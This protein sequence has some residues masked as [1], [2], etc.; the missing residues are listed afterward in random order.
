MTRL[1]KEGLVKT[2]SKG[3]RLGKLINKE[4]VEDAMKKYFD[5]NNKTTE[6]TTND[7]I[8]M[9]Q[10]NPVSI[11][12]CVYVM[13]NGSCSGDSRGDYATHITYGPTVLSCEESTIN[14]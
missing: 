10:N 5:R 11:T 7:D 4:M 12:I 13:Y 14:S 6:P 9:S 8:T 2:A 1:E 3:K